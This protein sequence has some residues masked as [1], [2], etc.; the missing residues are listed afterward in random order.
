MLTGVW[1]QDAWMDRLTAPSSFQGTKKE[2]EGE[3]LATEKRIKKG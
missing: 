1:E 3:C 2:K